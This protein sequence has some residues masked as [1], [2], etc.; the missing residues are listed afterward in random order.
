[1]E[2]TLGLAAGAVFAFFVLGTGKGIDIC[3]T[4]RKYRIHNKYAFIKTGKWE[5]L[6]RI[7]GILVMPEKRTSSNISFDTDFHLLNKTEH[8][9]FL[10]PK[11]HRQR[12]L[13]STLLSKKEAVEF[14]KDLSEQTNIPITNFNPPISRKTQERRNRRRSR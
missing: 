14:A 8:S 9:V 11:N 7:T 6:E 5:T 2:S 4:N 13:V 3:L 12:I 1:M 10:A